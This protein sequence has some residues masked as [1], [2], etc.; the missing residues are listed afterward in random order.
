MPGF[1]EDL[2]SGFTVIRLAGETRY[3]T[4]LEIL[5]EAGLE[6]EDLLVADGRGFADALSASALGRPIL[7]TDK[8]A[9]ALSEGQR[10]FLTA[11]E[12]SNVF[13]LGGESAVPGSIETELAE[14]LPGAVVERLAGADRYE[15]SV[16]IAERFFADAPYITLATGVNFPDGLTGGVL[17]GRIGAPLILTSDRHPEAARSYIGRNPATGA[18]IFGGESALGTE[19][20]GA[21]LGR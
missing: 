11:H 13:I 17:S 16:A 18:L 9:G 7:L 3:D 6:G 4:D 14:L 2:L 20:I 21:L 19:L 1:V 8:K 10:G 5:S 15:T 12:F